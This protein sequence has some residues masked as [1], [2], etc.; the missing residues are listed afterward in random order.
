MVDALVLSALWQGSWQLQIVILAALVAT[1]L[2]VTRFVT[3]LRFQ[4]ALS[5]DADVKMIPTFPYTIPIVG[6]A[7]HLGLDI[8]G[9][10]RDIAFVAFSLP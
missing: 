2:L 4:R 8:I 5:S 6:H 1:L 10:N 3:A 9:I 7:F